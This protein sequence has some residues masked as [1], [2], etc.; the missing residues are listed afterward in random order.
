[1]D[2]HKWKWIKLDEPEHRG[3]SIC[4]NCGVKVMSKK[5]EKIHLRC[6]T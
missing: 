5:Y 3:Y 2:E 4:L 1:M 6:L